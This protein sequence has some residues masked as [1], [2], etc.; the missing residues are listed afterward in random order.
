MNAT[1]P[2]PPPASDERLDIERLISRLLVWMTYVSV[3]LLVIGVALMLIDGISPL[4]DAPA[5]DP[6]MIVADITS[7][8]PVGFLWLGLIV[9]LLTPIVRV[10]V[11]GLGYARDR[12][13][14]MVLVAIGILAVIAIGVASAALTEV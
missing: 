10:V 5:F 1:H 4:D 13:W 14:V 3:V 11:A 9:V 12:E 8:R 7:L 2:G 6:T